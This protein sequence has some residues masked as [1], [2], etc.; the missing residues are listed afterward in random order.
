MREIQWCD[1]CNRFMC[2]ACEDEI[3]TVDLP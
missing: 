2:R 3:H 1:S